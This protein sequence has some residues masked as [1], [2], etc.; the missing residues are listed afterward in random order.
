MVEAKKYNLMENNIKI[1]I[2]AICF[3]G[4][5]SCQEKKQTISI[6]DNELKEKVEVKILKEFEPDSIINGILKLKNVESSIG[7]YPEINEVKLID[8]MAESPV[9]LLLNNSSSEYLMLYNY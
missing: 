3:F 5:I 8:F 6:N 9:K 4:L 2:Y 7:F 1:I